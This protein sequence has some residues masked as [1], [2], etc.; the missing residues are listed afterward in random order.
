MVQQISLQGFRNIASASVKFER[1]LV[2][3]YGQNGQG[4]TNLLES[5]AIVSCGSSFRDQKKHLWLPFGADQNHFASIVL[6]TDAE[7]THR[8]VVAAAA[9]TGLAQVKFWRN[10]IPVRLADF[11]GEI[12]VVVFRPEDM[13][14]FILDPTLRR[15][16]LDSVLFQIFPLYRQAY[17]Q[18][19]KTL[20]NRNALLKS[21][22]RGDAVMGE[23]SFWNEQF[24]QYSAVLQQYRAL[25][26]AYLDKELPTVYEQFSQVKLSLRVQ[27][28]KSLFEPEANA[29]LERSRGFTIS[30]AHRDDFS[31]FSEGSDVPWTITASRGEMRTLILALKSMLVTFLA[32]KLEQKPIVLLDDVLSEFDDERQELVLSWKADY[33]LFITV[34]GNINKI[35]DAQMIKVEKGH[36][37]L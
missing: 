3:F 16:F 14:L 6:S 20:I 37:V 28:Q 24:L 4:K 10:D 29:L 5:L 13:N 25:L 33:Q 30:G 36:I 2:V 8:V 1:P 31:I 18:A 21:I 22:Q 11:I 19:K 7:I 15:S 32:E 26:L 17:S 9:Q 27:Y 23:L 12:P 35:K 34:A